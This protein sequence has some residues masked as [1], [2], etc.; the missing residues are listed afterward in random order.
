MAESYQRNNAIVGFIVGVI[1]VGAVLVG[2]F[3]Y[4]GQTTYGWIHIS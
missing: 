2:T 1:V 3:A 4:L